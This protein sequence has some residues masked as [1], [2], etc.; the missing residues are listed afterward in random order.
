MKLQ[1]DLRGFVEL[2]V[3]RNDE[4]IVV[5]AYVRDP[6]RLSESSRLGGQQA[7]VRSEQRSRRP[8]DTRRRFLRG[9]LKNGFTRLAGGLSVEPSGRLR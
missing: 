2:L 8:R 9:L 1:T 3:S 6:R 7:R 5:G 4:F